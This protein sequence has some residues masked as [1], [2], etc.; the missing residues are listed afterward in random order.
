MSIKILSITKSTGGIAAY[1]SD[2]LQHLDRENF[3]SHSICLSDGA[4]SYADSL[5]S[6]GLDASTFAMSRYKVD[7]L[8][9][10]R[11]LSYIVSTARKYKPDVIMCHG[12]KAGILG[13]IA[14]CF[15]RC[16]TVYVQASMPFLE[17]I[18]GRSARVYKW[19][20]RMTSQIFGGYIVALTQTARET[21]ITHEIVSADRIDVISTGIDTVRFEPRSVA[22]D[23]AMSFGLDPAKAI[24][25]WIGRFEDQKAPLDFI[26]AMRRLSNRSQNFNVL[27]A[28]DGSLHPD[29]LDQIEQH[30]LRDVI[31]IVPWLS[32]PEDAYQVI[33]VFVL[34]SRWE[35]LPLTLLEAMSSACAPVSTSIDGC[36]EVIV[37]G[38]SGL[39]VPSSQPDALMEACY[40]LISNPDLLDLIKTAARKRVLDKYNREAMV[41]AWEKYLRDLV[42]SYDKGFVESADGKVST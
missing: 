42:P 34:S 40:S 15:L 39:L 21:S 7:F 26:D 10:V 6:N 1:N 3:T 5:R 41:A 38:E 24:I 23:V 29:I 18:Q 14:G 36:S 12:S 16:P 4:K 20:E 2:L 19:F 35:G 11:V 13:R 22:P 25:G 30:G 28:G 8:G 9:D 31:K 33:D 27:M 37:D 32:K 17:R